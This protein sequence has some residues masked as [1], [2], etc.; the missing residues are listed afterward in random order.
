MFGQSPGEI[1]L[2]IRVVFEIASETWKYPGGLSHNS[3]GL[4]H[5][6]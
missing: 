3:T 2:R 6:Q 4:S 5:R 1:E